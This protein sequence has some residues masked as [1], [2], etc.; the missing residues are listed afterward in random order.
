MGDFLARSVGGNSAC[1]PR[2]TVVSIGEKIVGIVLCSIVAF[3]VLA[4]LWAG[5]AALIR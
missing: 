2:R 4:T 1:R 5:A 3:V